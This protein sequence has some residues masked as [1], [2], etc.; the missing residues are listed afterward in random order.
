MA[1]GDAPK[2]ND[3]DV[4]DIVHADKHQQDIDGLSTRITQLENKFGTNEKI[5][6]TLCETAE[7]AS[8]MQEMLGK[9]FLKL[10][11]HDTDIGSE[12]EKIISKSDRN[13]FYRA[14]KRFGSV[15]GAIIL[16]LVGAVLYA[17]AA[18]YIH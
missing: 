5:A 15:S 17:L 7:K 3:F 1:K 18:K 12:F 10:L 11:Q 8:K 4:D 2:K 14:L 9:S 6:D 16:L 13:A